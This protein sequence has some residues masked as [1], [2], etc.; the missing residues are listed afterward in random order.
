MFEAYRLIGLFAETPLHPGTG[1]TTGVV[2][3][4]VQREKHTGFPIIQSSGLK[5]A[6]REKAEKELNNAAVVNAIFGPENSDHAG[7]IAVTDA[8][9]LA[10]PVRSLAGV[11]VWVT[12]PAVISRL[13]RDLAL[14]KMPIDKLHVLSP[15]KGQA[16]VI[17]N[18][19][20]GDK[21]ILEELL[22]DAVKEDAPKVK[23]CIDEICKFLPG[24]EAHKHIRDDKMKKHLVVIHNDDF[25][26]LVTTG[27]QVS[28]RIVLN[29]NKTSKNLW[30][31]ESLP[32][33]SLFYTMVMAAKPRGGNSGL[34]D[35]DAVLNKLGEAAG[36][37]LQV[38]GNETVGMGWCAVTVI[39]GTK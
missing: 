39:G 2:D 30:Y 1:T 8:R 10:F 18:A 34:A 21:L 15:E 26:Q 13:I 28:A 31:E 35:A 17:D 9:L 36:S 5:G 24:G 16:F 7:S 12:C 22:F 23:D 6:M 33:D 4:P 29:E 25:G 20:L 38:G 27:A 32:P 3:L 19:G 11:Y 14:A 37:Y